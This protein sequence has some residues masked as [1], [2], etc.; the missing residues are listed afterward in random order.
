M[1]K[2]YFKENKI[3]NTSEE[4]DKTTR[5]V[6]DG[7]YMIESF[8]VGDRVTSEL[9]PELPKGTWVASFY[10]EDEDYWNNVIMNDEFKGF[11]LEGKFIEKYEDEA[12][13]QLYSEIENVLNSDISDNEKEDKIKS[14]LN[15]K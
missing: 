7:I 6:G 10:I 3:H 15:I 1:M 9:Y 13:D 2:K 14:L 11:S 12:V 4:H 8:I 5:R